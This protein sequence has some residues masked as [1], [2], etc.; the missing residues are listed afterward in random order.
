M[1]ILDF[2]IFAHAL[3]TIVQNAKESFA[4]SFVKG[5]GNVAYG[6]LYHLVVG[7]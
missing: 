3:G 1:Y 6:A 5:L 4:V 7:L 2:H